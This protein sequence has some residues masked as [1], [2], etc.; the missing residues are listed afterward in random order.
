MSDS[1][2][3]PR[4]GLSISWNAD[5]TVGA[6]PQLHAIAEALLTPSKTPIALAYRRSASS[7]RSKEARN[8]YQKQRSKADRDLIKQLK[9]DPEA[10]AKLR[11]QVRREQGL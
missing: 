5:R 6:I 8:A 11:E 10:F 1:E 9:A 3:A 7:S 4:H 2:D